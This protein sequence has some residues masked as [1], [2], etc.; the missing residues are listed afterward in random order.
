MRMVEVGV[1]QA[2]GAGLRRWV[3]LSMRHPALAMGVGLG[4]TG[5]LQSSTATAMITASFVRQGLVETA[6]ALA[7]MLGADVG[8]SLVVQVLSFDLGWLAPL[9]ILVGVVGFKTSRAATRQHVSRAVIGLGL[10]LLALRQMVGVSQPLRSATV[11]QQVLEALSGEPMLLVVFAALLTWLAHSSLAV[12]LLVAS[13]A[14]SGAFSLP[15]SLA[16]VL[17]ANLGGGIPQLTA[18][19]GSPPEVRRVPLGNLLF[20]LCGVVVALVLLEEATGWIAQLGG[21]PGRQVAHFHLAFNLCLAAV[22]GFLTRPVAA[23]L[24][25][26][27]PDVVGVDDPGEPRYLDRSAIESPTLALAHAERETLRMGD[28]VERMVARTIDVLRTNDEVLLREIVR[29]DD[30][31]DSLH[32]AIKFYLTDMTREPMNEKES[33]RAQEVLSFTI[34]LEHIGD[35]VDKGLMELAAKKARQQVQFSEEGFLDITRLHKRLMDNFRLAF[36]VFMSGEVEM[37]RRLLVE[38]TAFREMEREA[39]DRHLARLR[40]NRLESIDTSSIH[41]D[42]LIELKR[43]NSHLTSVAYPILEQAGELFSTRLKPST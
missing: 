25:R 43:I 16:L 41:L 3:G 13:Q 14:G 38:K 34:N 1:N 19:L 28:V 33:L 15:M 23:V 6:P 26:M 35:I 18:T 39:A 2:F 7:V 31:V 40:R 5:L 9:L 24:T 20:K 32:Q 12:V 30:A 11:L 37:A 42:I 36:A 8:T 4:V 10:I 22:F 27:L 21:S 17:G 29:Q